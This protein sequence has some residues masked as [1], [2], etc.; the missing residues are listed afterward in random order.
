MNAKPHRPLAVTLFALLVLTVAAVNL[1]RLF[2]TLRDWEFLSTLLPFSPLYFV[3][4]GL[5]WGA[6]G[7]GLCWGLWRGLS[8][9]PRWSMAAI[10][11]YS[12]YIWFDR[13]V[14]PG[15]QARTQNWPFVLLLNLLVAGAGF[16]T[17]SH[18]HSRSFFGELHDRE[19]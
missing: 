12:A 9:A 3:I 5:F 11:L 8:W 16:L 7:L 13:L 19:P 18:I 4:T 14:M 2:L 10:L 15:Y 17:L 1:I 6:L